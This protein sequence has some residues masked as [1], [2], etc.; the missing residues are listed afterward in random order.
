MLGQ[1]LSK[2]ISR[3]KP[4]NAS[5]LSKIDEDG[6]ETGFGSNKDRSPMSGFFGDFPQPQKKSLNATAAKAL[7]DRL[8]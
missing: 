2:I 6:T 1:P 4:K 3:D 8:S 7:A 5:P